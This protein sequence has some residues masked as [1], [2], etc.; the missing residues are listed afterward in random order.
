MRDVICLSDDEEWRVCPFNDN[1]QV[2]NRGR[3]RRATFS[4]NR[5]SKPGDIIK[6][7]ISNQGYYTVALWENGV[8][9]R[10]QVHRLVAY[11]FLG[12]P[13]QKSYEVAH[14]DGDRKNPSASN[15]RWATRSENH[16]DKHIHGTN[17]NGER[18]NNSKLTVEQVMDILSYPPG[19]NKSE[20][21]RKHGIKPIT[22]SRI[23][24]RMLWKHV[25]LEEIK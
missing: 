3:I 15:L 16:S 11:A 5:K 1:Y 19:Y 2:S 4:Q 7:A 24:R 23:I 17:Q 18:N 12:Y 22:A 25:T 6:P 13:P 20:I 10:Y 14:N 21:A 8:S 9:K